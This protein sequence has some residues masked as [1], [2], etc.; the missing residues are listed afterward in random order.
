MIGKVSK[1]TSQPGRPDSDFLDLIYRRT[2]HQQRQSQEQFVNSILDI[3]KVNP[4]SFVWVMFDLQVQEYG[5]KYWTAVH[6]VGVVMESFS[7]YLR[8][9]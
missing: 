4:V 3:I 1:E 8:Y 9:T 2:V 6:D 7:N 5:T